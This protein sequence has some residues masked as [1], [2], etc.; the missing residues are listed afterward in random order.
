MKLVRLASGRGGTAVVV[1]PGFMTEASDQAGY[2]ASLRGGRF[3]GD[4][5]AVRWPSGSP[6]EMV[7][8]GGGTAMAAG[9]LVKL[10][11]LGPVAWPLVVAG[12]AAAGWGY[13]QSKVRLARTI[14]PQVRKRLHELRR[15]HGY[16]K[17]VLLAHSLGAELTWTMLETARY[18]PFDRLVLLGGASSATDGCWDSLEI[19][20]EVYNV[21]HR[22]DWVL[23]FFYLVAE[24]EVPLG[25]ADAGGQ[26]INVDA[27][28]MALP[29]G[30]HTYHPLFR[31]WESPHRWRPSDFES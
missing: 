7:A 2:A 30:G 13:W 12:G 11:A 4:I 8:A 3:G 6:L 28:G 5:W 15:Y 31:H 9:L 29:D 22:N 21:G 20:A 23:K 1:I 24:R 27:G 16:R 14:A 17:V 25:L 10:L 26:L 18:I 19:E